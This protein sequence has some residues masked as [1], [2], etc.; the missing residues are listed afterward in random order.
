MKT[1][2][3]DGGVCPHASSV[4][5]SSICS[6]C[7]LGGLGGPRWILMASSLV[8]SVVPRPLSLCGPGEIR[9]SLGCRDEVMT[10]GLRECFSAGE[11][12]GILRVS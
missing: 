11:Q 9:V 6:S 8:P 3:M 4:C 10:H 12:C 2:V 7:L 5:G 1:R